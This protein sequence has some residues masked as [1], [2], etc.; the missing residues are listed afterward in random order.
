MRLCGFVLR[1]LQ[2]VRHRCLVRSSG[3]SAWPHPKRFGVRS[4]VEVG[5]QYRTLDFFHSELCAQEH[6]HIVMLEQFKLRES[7]VVCFQLYANSW[8]YVWYVYDR[9]VFTYFWLCSFLWSLR[10]MHALAVSLWWLRKCRYIIR[11][12]VVLS[13]CFTNVFCTDGSAY[14]SDERS[15]SNLCLSCASL[16]SF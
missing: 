9:Q 16:F 11:F 13:F 8:W 3:G 15:I 1:Q 5:A 12:A 2:E 4:G 14:K 6:C 7:A 10:S